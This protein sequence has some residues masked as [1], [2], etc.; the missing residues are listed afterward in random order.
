[1]VD[2]PHNGKILI[3]G[4]GDP[5]K[6]FFEPTLIV[7]PKEESR[8]MKEEIFGPILPVVGFKDIEEVVSKLKNEAKPLCLYYFGGM[9]NHNKKKILNETS[10]GMK[11][12]KQINKF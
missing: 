3:G 12:I 11:L 2:E 6:R 10:S 7:D 4:K 5:Q 1:M 9:R 8:I